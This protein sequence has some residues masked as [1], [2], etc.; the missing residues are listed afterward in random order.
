MVTVGEWL[1][2]EF[3]TKGVK[4]VL[5]DRIKL[6]L[7]AASAKGLWDMDDVPSF[8]AVDEAHLDEAGKMLKR[9]L[10]TVLTD[11]EAESKAAVAKAGSGEPAAFTGTER[12]RLDEWVDGL[13][14][15]YKQPAVTPQKL[16]AAQDGQLQADLKTQG[17]TDES[18][19]LWFELT[20][21]TGRPA[22]PGDTDGGTY[23]GKA[24]ATKGGVAHRKAGE[25]AYSKVL[26]DAV[27]NEDFGRIER[28]NEQLVEVL[29]SSEH[30]Y[31]S[32][33]SLLIMGMMQKLT[34]TLGA[35]KHALLYLQL[36]EE[37]HTGR[38]FPN[39]KMLDEGIY[40]TVIGRSILAPAHGGL[41]SLKSSARA[42]ASET[43]G[44][45]VSGSSFQSSLGSSASSPSAALEGQLGKMMEALTGLGSKMDEQSEK[46]STVTRR[47]QSVEDKVANTAKG[48]KCNK[49]KQF[50]HIA[51]NCTNEAKKEE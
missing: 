1:G 31:A 36:H 3:K 26:K 33:A 42:P 23:L 7:A 40:K 14:L 2:A 11:V 22:A 49:C 12:M 47:L 9:F 19:L 38:G 4:R 13:V 16:S 43:G 21:H 27:A 20:R 18:D 10:G 17:M 28:W 15:S 46:I 51:A 32:Q 50:G 41:E 30:R 45:T 34:S 8:G 35:G 6:V 44:S 5:S 24:S 29:D 37:R 39:G 25:E 48:P